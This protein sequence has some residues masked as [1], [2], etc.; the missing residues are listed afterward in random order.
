[1]PPA[2]RPEASLYHVRI[3]IILIGTYCIIRGNT[4]GPGERCSVPRCH[5]HESANADLR[6]R[7]KSSARTGSIA[8]RSPMHVL[9]GSLKPR[10]MWT[11]RSRS[12]HLQRTGQTPMMETKYS[13]TLG[14]G[15]PLSVAL[16]LLSSDGLRDEMRNAGSV[17]TRRCVMKCTGRRQHASAYPVI[18]VA[19]VSGCET[20]RENT[21]RL[22]NA[23]EECINTKGTPLQT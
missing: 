18:E 3:Y 9:P 22:M 7:A 19:L 12:S 2:L 16:A 8:R 20:R 17:R 14:R 11:R 1:M 6:E 5:G 21:L 13:T 4:Q 15:Q 23:P 10:A